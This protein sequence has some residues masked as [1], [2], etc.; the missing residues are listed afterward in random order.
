M[1]RLIALGERA[2]HDKVDAYWLLT[3]SDLAAITNLPTTEVDR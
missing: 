1:N 3:Q 2:F